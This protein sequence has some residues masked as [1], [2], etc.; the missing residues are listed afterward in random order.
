M[1]SKRN[2]KNGAVGSTAGLVFGTS[3]PSTGVEDKE[4]A[5][6]RKANGDGFF[7]WNGVPRW[8]DA[9]SPLRLKVKENASTALPV[10]VHALC[11]RERSVN[12]RG[13]Y[14][15][16]GRQPGDTAFYSVDLASQVIIG[17]SR[18]YSSTACNPLDLY[19]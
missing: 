4:A 19:T 8:Q 12:D 15:I 9:Q 5:H 6:G 7:V 11:R 13:G 16:A 1:S 14:I 3:R 2:D 18:A 10:F 17:T